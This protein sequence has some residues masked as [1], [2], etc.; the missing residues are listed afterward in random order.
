MDLTPH[1]AC[2]LFPL[3]DDEALR[4]L[5]DDIAQNGLIEPI[6]TFRGLLIDGRNRLRACDLVDVEPVTREFE[7]DE[8]DVVPWI[9]SKNLHRRH[10][11]TSQRAMVAARLATLQ[12]G[13]NRYTMTG[14][15]AGLPQ[16]EAA[17]LMSVGERTVRDARVV[18]HSGDEDL[19]AAVDRGEI[20]VSTAAEQ[21]RATTRSV[22]PADAPEAPHPPADDTDTGRSMSVEAQPLDAPGAEEQRVAARSALTSSATNEWYTPPEYVE[23]ARALMGGIDLDPAS[24]ATAN[25]TV[26]AERFFTAKDDGLSQEWAGRVWMNPPYGKEDGKSNQGRWTARLIEQYEACAID[27]AVFLVNATTDRAWFKPLWSYPICFVDQ[28]IQFLDPNGNRQTSPTH[29]NALVYLGPRIDRFVEI[30]SQFGQV[31]VPDG[32]VSRAVLR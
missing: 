11:T 18:L 10:L 12:H 9:V 16:P 24:C 6:V 28:R 32:N 3:L 27:Q 22:E 21:V 5:A 7:G 20:A 17:G 8:A 1:P 25:E 13:A 14:K 26:Q 4:K 2:E 29:G 19:V 15:S 31:V 23:A 30:F